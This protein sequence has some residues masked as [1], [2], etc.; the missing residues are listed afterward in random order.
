MR[1]KTLFMTR[2]NPFHYCLTRDAP[3]VRHGGGLGVAW[4][5]WGAVSE[6][7]GSGSG[8]R[9]NRAHQGRVGARALEISSGARVRKVIRSAP[10]GTPAG[11]QHDWMADILLRVPGSVTRDML[12][13]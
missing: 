8:Q 2:A 12:T 6:S 10:A 4:P 7:S 13:S 3:D 9:G 1:P 5:H 11:G